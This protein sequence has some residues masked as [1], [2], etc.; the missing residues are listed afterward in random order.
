[1]NTTQVLLIV[2]GI[3]IGVAVVLCLALPYLKRKGIDLSGIIAKSKEAVESVNAAMTTIRPFLN[4]SP[5]LAI[6]DKILGIAK[7]AVGN[8]EQL[9]HIGQLEADQRKAEATDY[10]YQALAL[11][12]V[13]VTPEVTAVVEGA[14][15]ANVL[16]LGHK[17]KKE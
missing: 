16:E 2:L 15:E 1:M 13:E 10:I 14:I 8:A 12:G 5:G 9:Y 11:A 4:Q 7:I 17:P 6:F 3:I